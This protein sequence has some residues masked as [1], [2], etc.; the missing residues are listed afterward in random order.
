MVRLE[1]IALC[2]LETVQCTVY[3][4]QYT[5]Y[6]K[7]MAFIVDD[8]LKICEEYKN[9][10]IENVWI[11]YVYIYRIYEYFSYFVLMVHKQMSKARPPN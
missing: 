4:M 10:H 9:M 7:V 11:E 5:V 1:V 3:S 6:S 2:N 8:N